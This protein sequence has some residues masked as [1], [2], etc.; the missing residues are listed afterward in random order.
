LLSRSKLAIVV[1]AVVALGGV[2]WVYSFHPGTGHAAKGGPVV[3]IRSIDVNE[4]STVFVNLLLQ[5]EPN[6][7]NT[8]AGQPFSFNLTV[9]F[10]RTLDEGVVQTNATAIRGTLL[11]LT[12]GFTIDHVYQVGTYVDSNQI[13]VAGDT[14]TTVTVH[15]TAPNAPYTGD[16]NLLLKVTPY[17]P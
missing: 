1:V 11:L 14:T 17:P 3:R 12:P 15:M 2:V 7:I 5:T 4:S 8:T 16:L 13:V 10:F 9:G 6:Q